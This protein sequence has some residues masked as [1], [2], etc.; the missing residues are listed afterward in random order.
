MGAAIYTTGESYYDR[1]QVY[2]RR[3]PTIL[4]VDD[5]SS[6]LHMVSDVLEDEDLRV[7]TARSGQEALIMATRERPDLII[8]DL[9]MPGI[10]GRVLRE[11]LRS[12][13]QTAAIPVLLMTAA[14]QVQA[15]QEFS[16][17]IAKPFDI[18]EL[19]A[20]VHQHLH[21]T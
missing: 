5:E 6:V 17:L 1:R 2:T 13:P 18:D 16:G 4:V 20:Q 19:V 10:N 12:Q 8:T 3:K 11:R 7:L 9:M 14:Y 15:A 21:S